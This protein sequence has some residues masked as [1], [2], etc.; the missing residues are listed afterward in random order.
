[1]SEFEDALR[2]GGL[3]P[4]A[5]GGCA[6]RW[7]SLLERFTL[8]ADSPPARPTELRRQNRRMQTK[9]AMSF[10]NAAMLCLL[11]ALA[12]LAVIAQNNWLQL[13]WAQ[14][15]FMGSNPPGRF[16]SACAWDAVKSQ[17]YCAGGSTGPVGD[18]NEM[19]DLWYVYRHCSDKSLFNASRLIS[20]ERPSRVSSPGCGTG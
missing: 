16:S 5:A 9:S 14:L 19:R 17:L 8:A 4:A 11:A 2:F 3:P 15:P 10:G 1:M 6:F 12:P 7:D 20:E 18:F 13:S